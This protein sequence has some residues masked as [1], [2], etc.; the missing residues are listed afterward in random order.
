MENAQL[1]QYFK[2]KGMRPAEVAHVLD[3]HPT[4]VSQLLHG[5]M[6]LTDSARFKIVKAFP[7]TAAF[8]LQIELPVPEAS[9]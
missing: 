3:M 7:E 2:D 4:Y 8:L 5:S 9:R 1:Y 6:P